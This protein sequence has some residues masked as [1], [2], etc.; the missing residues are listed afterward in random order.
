[1][2]QETDKLRNPDGTFQPGHPAPPA[3]IRRQKGT[4]NKITRDIKNGIV[5]AAVKLGSDGKGKDG[6]V[7]YLR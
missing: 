1:M 3:H 7:G 2:E 5:E 4:P 6:L